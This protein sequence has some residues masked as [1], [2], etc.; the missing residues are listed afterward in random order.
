[1]SCG[2]Q[3]AGGGSKKMQTETCVNQKFAV[4][5]AECWRRGC[6]SVVAAGCCL[7]VGC[8]AA[9]GGAR[10]ARAA[11]HPHHRLHVLPRLTDRLACCCEAAAQAVRPGGRLCSCCGGVGGAWWWWSMQWHAHPMLP[12]LC[13][14]LHVV[15]N[16][17]CSMR[18]GI[19]CAVCMLVMCGRRCDGHGGM[20]CVM[21]GPVVR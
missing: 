9:A 7:R 18:S 5:S 3:W 12:R 4:K 17:W 21:C 14:R 6:T 11:A 13:A 16:M 1:M 2:A 15:C 20:G 10:A 8:R 19:G